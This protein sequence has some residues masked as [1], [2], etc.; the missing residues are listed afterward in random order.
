MNL[1]WLVVRVVDIL[2]P[3]SWPDCKASCYKYQESQMPS[4]TS[5]ERTEEVVDWFMQKMFLKSGN[6]RLPFPTGCNRHSP[7][8]LIRNSH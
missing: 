4:L 1:P 7:S 6:S 8:L 5:P 3:R 2:F